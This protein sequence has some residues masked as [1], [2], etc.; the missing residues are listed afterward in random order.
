MPTL[1]LIVLGGAVVLH[2][3]VR[4][5]ARRNEARAEAAR[6]PEG[7]FLEVEGVKVHAVVSGAGPDLVLIHG[8]GGNWRDMTLSLAPLLADRYR[9]IAIDRPGLGYTGKP[10]SSGPSIA[11]QAR[12]MA[13]AARQLGAE[14]PLVLG[15]SYGGTVALA[16][17]VT[18]PDR[19]SAVIPVAAP[20]I[21]WDTGLSALHRVSSRLLGKALVVPM[22]TAFVTPR[23]IKRTVDAI[24]APQPAPEGYAEAVGA[25]LA[26]RRAAL[27]ATGQQRAGLLDEVRAMEPRYGEIAVPVEL[28][29]GTADEVVAHDHHSDQLAPR[30]SGANYVTL[31]G[32]GHM[33]QHVA[34]E[35][36]VAAVDRAAA[37]AGLR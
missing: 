14:R 5:R 33:V 26:L 7:Q 9:V 24:F 1:L 34:P 21:P 8:T 28:L 37:R 3:M 36:V 20:S 16:W 4:W 29:H 23:A 11:E 13:E 18:L 12:I 15:H 35:A 17:A 10:D 25:R 19:L 31:P 22:I 27:K 32:I 6:P 2:V 30:I